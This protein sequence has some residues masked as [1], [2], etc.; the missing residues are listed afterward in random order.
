M[1]KKLFIYGAGGHAKVVADTAFLLGYDLLGFIDDTISESTNYLG[2][3]VL[4]E[5]PS[6]EDFSIICAIGDCDS[7]FLICQRL[8]KSGYRFATII[9]PSAIISNMATI[10]QGVYL[11]AGSIVDPGCII[12][13]WSIVNNHATIC[14][15]TCLGLACHV[16]PGATIASSCNIGDAVWIGVGASVIHKINIGKRVF[17]G[18]GAAVVKDISANCL[19]YGVPAREIRSR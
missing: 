3:I 13:S 4:H 15:D 11:G 10:G 1:N 19:A 18:G 5:L 16:A 14:H 12:G 17:I 2:K 8:E 7:R 9:H 6:P